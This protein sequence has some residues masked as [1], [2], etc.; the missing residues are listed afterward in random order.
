MWRT[1][2][3]KQCFTHRTASTSRGSPHRG[4][5]KRGGPHR[6]RIEVPRRRYLIGI[7]APCGA[8]VGVHLFDPKG[9]CI[10]TIDSANGKIVAAAW[11]IEDRSIAARRRE[12]TALADPSALARHRSRIVK[13]ICAQ[14]Q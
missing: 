8:D 10:S 13:G 14:K 1:N 12:I 11:A 3:L 4:H 6:Y 2:R 9:I 7:V 5:A